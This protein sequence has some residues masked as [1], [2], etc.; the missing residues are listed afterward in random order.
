MAS[1]ARVEIPLGPTGET[2]GL[3]EALERPLADTVGLEINGIVGQGGLHQLL[4]AQGGLMLAGAGI[5]VQN[6]R[7][8]LRQIDANHKREEVLFEDPDVTE[9][10]AHVLTP[11]APNYGFDVEEEAAVG[12]PLRMSLGLVAA[13]TLTDAEPFVGVRCNLWVTRDYQSPINNRRVMKESTG[14]YTGQTQ[15]EVMA[16]VWGL[17]RSQYMSAP[18]IERMFG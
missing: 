3:A 11:F 10:V 7:H 16:R 12:R 5:H 13:R 6:M 14:R 17:Q 8:A 4:A 2:I 1:R 18:F 9:L 15:D